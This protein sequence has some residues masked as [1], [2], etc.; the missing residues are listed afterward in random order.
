MLRPR[1][2]EYVVVSV[3]GSL[4]VPGELDTEFLTRFR[5]LILSKVAEG[6]SFYIITGG[7][8]TARR[9]QDAAEGV[10]GDLSAE[11]IDWL[12]IHATR[13]NGHLMRT[14]FR[15]EAQPRLVKNPSR[16]VTAKYPVIIGGGWKPGNS[17]DFC[18]V[19]AA[20]KLGAKK[21]VNL[22]NID[23]VYDKDP[24]KFEDA[25]KIERIG[26]KEFRTLI[27]AEWDP[28]L[29][30]PFDPVA[31]RE[32]EALKLEVAIINGNKLEEFEKYLSGDS[33]TGTIIH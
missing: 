9:Y 32:A 28:G 29:S 31:A 30:S 21:L 16:Y 15:E 27:P 1:K 33:F 18:A 6:T 11:D 22:S 19:L 8:K 12:G 3:G 5:E 2:R 17:S 14:L 25:Q 24:R 20:K 13:I 26:W 4:I 10:R 7:G 23:Y